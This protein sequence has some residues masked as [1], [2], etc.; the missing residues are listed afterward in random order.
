MAGNHRAP[1]PARDSCIKLV[2]QDL[3]NFEDNRPKLLIEI[4][5]TK[6]D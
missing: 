5:K 2:A 1:C 3:I 6:R 4:D